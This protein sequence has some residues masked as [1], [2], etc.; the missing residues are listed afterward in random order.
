M[1]LTLNQQVIAQ[2]VLENLIQTKTPVSYAEFALRLELTGPQKI[3]RIIKWLEQITLE[4]A[5]KGVPVRAS[6]VFS[7]LHLGLP[8]SG[9][10]EFCK[11]I[12]LFDWNN[13]PSRAQNFIQYQ[14][15]AL[16]SKKT[17]CK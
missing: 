14:Q 10:F 6:M 7:K 1:R 9:F 15:K 2:V 5:S 8:S 3:H 16:F 13:E 17:A 12:G 11:E 4:D